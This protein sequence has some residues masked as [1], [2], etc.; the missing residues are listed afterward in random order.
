MRGGANHAVRKLSLTAGH[1]VQPVYNLAWNRL[2]GWY[3]TF[4][5]PGA[6]LSNFFSHYP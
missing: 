3:G 5:G 4:P 2:V 6:Q 1:V